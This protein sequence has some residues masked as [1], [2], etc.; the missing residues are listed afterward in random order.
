LWRRRFGADSGVLGRVVSLNGTPHTVIGVLPPPHQFPGDQQLWVPITLDPSRFRGNHYLEVIGRLRPGATPRAAQTELAAVARRLEQQYPETNSGATVSV[1]PLRDNEVGEYRTVLIIMMVAVA[2]VLLIACANVANL[3]LARAA[4][5]HR[6]IAIRVAVGAGRRRLLRQLLTESVLLA[7]AGAALGT[8]VALWGLDLIVAA[9]PEDKPFWMVFTIDARVLAFTAA[10]AVATGVLFGLAPALHALK[11]DVHDALKEGARGAGIG[12]GRQRLRHGLV[13]A[14]VALSVVLL[15]GATL[16]IRS[17]LRLQAVDPGYDRHNL[18]ALSVYL[19]GPAYDSAYERTG[20]YAGALPRLAALP[21]VEA[22]AASHAPPLAGSRTSSTISIEGQ[23]VETGREPSASWQAVTAGYVTLLRVPLLRG[24]DLTEQD[25]RDSA[26]VAVVGR[27]MAARFWPD[28]DPI[29][30]RFRFG[31][32]EENPWITVIGVAGDVR[33]RR[34]SEPPQNHFYIGYPL[35][36]FRGMM[37]LVRTEGDPAGVT[38]AAR[39]TI[40]E[41]DPALPVYA[42]Q[43]MDALYRS[44]MWEQRLYGWMFGAFAGVAVLL[45]VTGLYGVM[46]YLVTLRTHE[47]G[48]RMALGARTR[49]VARLVLRR[50]GRL[51]AAGIGIGLL[52][53]LGLTQALTGFLFGVSPT[54]PLTFLAIPLLLAAVALTASWIPARRAARVDPMLALRYE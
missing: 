18:L 41:A 19:A 50:G 48:V 46:A 51:A 3:L 23:P 7:L 45:A 9:V 31:S 53:A 30:K 42:A 36:P 21:G 11:T 52:G 47:I 44:S 22:V 20:F 15:I 35:A 25:V 12:P 2:F 32:S 14:E 29:G 17:F 49:D 37:I 43:T 34:L 1:V 27:T 5:R 33:I 10:V 28:A 4:G 24:R 8:L 26:R 38:R 16:M 6:E 40:R 54:D 13:V 39:E